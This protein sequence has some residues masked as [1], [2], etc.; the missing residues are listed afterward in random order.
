M[1][2]YQCAFVGCT[3]AP[4]RHLAQSVFQLQRSEADLIQIQGRHASFNGRCWEQL[5]ETAGSDS[6]SHANAGLLYRL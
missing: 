2:P 4:E 3:D 5:L 1:Y 6:R